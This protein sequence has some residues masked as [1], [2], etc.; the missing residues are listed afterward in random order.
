MWALAATNAAEKGFPQASSSPPWIDLAKN[1]FN[2]QA[3]RW[4]NSTCDGGLR[5]QIFAFNSGYDYKDA[6]SQATFFLLA[7]RLA[8]YTKNETYADW[9]NKAWDWT[10]KTGVISDD[11]KVYDGTL[12]TEDCGSVNKIQW[13]YNAAAFT[14]GSA[15][16]SNHVRFRRSSP[17]LQLLT[18]YRRMV[19]KDGKIGPNPWRLQCPRSGLE[20]PSTRASW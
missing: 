12:V 14:Y 16:M 19:I 1:V 7:A 8:Q 15:V 13:S 20:R 17:Y 3:A 10:K 2:S 4:D 9:A 5:W 18:L 11:F 6:A